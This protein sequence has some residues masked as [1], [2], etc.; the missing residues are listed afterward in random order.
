M[1]PNFQYFTTLMEY[2]NYGYFNDTSNG[3]V[4]LDHGIGF[5]YIRLSWDLKAAWNGRVVIEI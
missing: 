3:T 5:K 4:G 1:E 2:G